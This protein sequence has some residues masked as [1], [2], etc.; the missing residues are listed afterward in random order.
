MVKAGGASQLRVLC[1]S[2]AIR[3][4]PRWTIGGDVD[5]H[6]IKLQNYPQSNINIQGN[7]KSTIPTK[8]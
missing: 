1:P 5:S 3:H 2:Q 8:L 7:V 4:D 6:K